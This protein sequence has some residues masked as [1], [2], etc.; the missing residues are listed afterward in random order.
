MK[1]L[2]AILLSTSLA[3]SFLATASLDV[4]ASH[5]SDEGDSKATPKKA[6]LRRSTLD[7]TQVGSPRK[8]QAGNQKLFPNGFTY[9]A[10][11][12]NPK[13]VKDLETAQTEV[14]DY[15][16]NM[17]L[18]AIE[19]LQDELD[20]TEAFEKGQEFF[21]EELEFDAQNPGQSYIA[22]LSYSLDKKILVAQDSAL[23]DAL[24]LALTYSEYT[25]TV[26]G[27]LGITK[28]T[29]KDFYDLI[30]EA[31]SNTFGEWL[32]EDEDDSS[33]DSGSS[34]DE[35]D[36]SG[37]KDKKHE[38]SSE[39][40]PVKKTSK[41]ATQKAPKK[42]SSSEESSSESSESDKEA[43]TSK[44]RRNLAKGLDAIAKD[45]EK[46]A[47]SKGSSGEDE[48]DDDQFLNTSGAPLD[49]GDSEGEDLPGKIEE[50]EEKIESL[51]GEVE[52]KSKALERFK[53]SM[54]SKEEGLHKEIEE[55]EKRLKES[56]PA[57]KFLQVLL[58]VHGI[59]LENLW[60]FIDLSATALDQSTDLPWPALGIS[61]MQKL[62]MLKAMFTPE[63]LHL[64]I[65]G[66][67]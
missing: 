49:F 28:K 57:N 26:A 9:P 17:A 33:G 44:V 40:S 16:K 51:E 18:K 45:H 67:K 64:Y 14:V 43:S 2:R 24:V 20:E 13:A 58:H 10:R 25:S 7:F 66:K 34:S 29:V 65:E 62:D 37:D 38:S 1:K 6:T 4:Y 60:Q 23:I 32:P 22:A 46:S 35:G 55:R 50:L 11:G 39:S 53:K 63:V 42:P 30:V 3:T 5:L 21:D 27:K 59:S 36:L 41:K 48:E 61:D 52:E 12:G 15:A 8:V 19:R 56:E 47:Q 31:R 54:V